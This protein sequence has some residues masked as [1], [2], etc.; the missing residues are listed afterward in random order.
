MSRTRWLPKLKME[1]PSNRRTRDDYESRKDKL[2]QARAVLSIA[3]VI[4][5]ELKISLPDVRACGFAIA[6]SSPVVSRAV[7]AWLW[8]DTGWGSS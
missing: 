8:P 4:L 3:R 6:R 1:H 2:F 7:A 5:G